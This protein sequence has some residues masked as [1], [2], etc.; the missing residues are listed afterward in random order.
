MALLWALNRRTF[1][2]IDQ[3]GLL[4]YASAESTRYEIWPFEGDEDATKGCVLSS[5]TE[6]EDDDDEAE[7]IGRYKTIEE[8]QM[9]AELHDI[10]NSEQ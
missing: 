9:N 5:V 7:V 10:Q 6:G 8:A 3:D 4:A 2:G 1:G